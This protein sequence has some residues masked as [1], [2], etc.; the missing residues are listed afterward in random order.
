MLSDDDRDRSD[1]KRPDFCLRD[2][3]S[4]T[5]LSIE[6]RDRSDS[7]R[8]DDS[9]SPTLPSNDGRGRSDGERPDSILRDTDLLRSRGESF[10]S[11]I[12]RCEPLLA[13]LGIKELEPSFDC[14]R[15]ER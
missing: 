1:A 11:G 14:D 3:D 6:D 13:M 15:P 10:D 12:C 7:A 8:P 4:T 5:L 2:S 9:N